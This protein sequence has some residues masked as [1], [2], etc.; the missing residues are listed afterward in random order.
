MKKFQNNVFFSRHTK[1][2]SL[3]YILQSYIVKDKLESNNNHLE[4]LLKLYLSINDFK[5]DTGTFN[6]YLTNN[7]LFQYRDNFLHQLARC[8]KIFL[9][10]VY[11]NKYSTIF[12]NHYKIELKD[13]VYSIYYLAIFYNT[14]NF[15]KH[16]LKTWLL[17]INDNPITQYKNKLFE[18]VLNIISF[19][20]KNGKE[21]SNKT[22]RD[23]Y[24]FD[25][26]RN[27]PFVKVF[28]SFYLPIDGV[29]I[30]NLI[31]NNL[32]YKIFD[33]LEE[34]DE[35]SDYMSC[36]GLD[37]ENY[38]SELTKFAVENNKS[39]DYIYIEEFEFQYKKNK[40]KSP[41]IMIFDKQK[42]ILLAI[43]VKSAR[44]LNSILNPINDDNSIHESYEKIKLKPLKQVYAS[45]L[46]IVECK[47][48]ENINKDTTYMFLAISMNDIPLSG[49]QYEIKINDSR[50]LAFYSMNIEAFEVF[51]KIISSDYDFSF[52]QI[53]RGYNKHKEKMSIKTYL[54]KIIRHNKIE[55][56]KFDDYFLN[57]QNNYLDF[58]NN[59]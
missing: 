59:V 2:I 46:K 10:G 28:N 49:I 37:F 7:S 18:Q 22:I 51:L 15:N 31:F 57:S 6:H 17:D 34:K 27:K 21:F 43:E 47:T 33:V 58:I 26:F 55:N 11:Q 36:F 9:N 38:A 52:S 3:K 1:L 4:T 42:N 39:F 29:F 5:L 12:K 13:Y 50:S 44:V 20:I 24:N 30:E 14:F 40:L 19:D 53:L 48:H 8:E 54:A 25:L 23:F 56:K 35:K 45:I 41:D 32:F 16:N